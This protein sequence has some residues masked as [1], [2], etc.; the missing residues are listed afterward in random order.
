MIKQMD[1][2]M[3]LANDVD[4]F[5]FYFYNLVLWFVGT[6]CNFRSI[7]TSKLSESY[8]FR[9][10]WG[11]WILTSFSILASMRK[12]IFNS[13]STTKSPQHKINQ[14]HLFYVHCGQFSNFNQPSF[15]KK[16]LICL[17]RQTGTYQLRYFLPTS[18]PDV[19]EELTFKTKFSICT[20]CY[21][22]NRLD[23]TGPY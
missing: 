9:Y 17:Q 3:G 14:H 23:I 11:P 20:Q 5:Q 4:V 2:I 7:S 12:F 21:A 13:I 15:E 8:S 22:T 1:F 6:A 10:L 16:K 19:K 18:H